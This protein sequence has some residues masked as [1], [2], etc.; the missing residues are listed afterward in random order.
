VDGET[1]AVEALKDNR[2]TVARAKTERFAAV[3]VGAAA[4]SRATIPTTL[5]TIEPLASGPV[6]PIFGG[7]GQRRAAGVPVLGAHD[8]RAAQG[9]RAHRMGGGR[10]RG[11]W[12]YHC[13]ILEPTSRE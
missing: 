2:M 13:H 12:M 4:P 8:Q 9:A 7:R 5:R 11:D 1:V 6:S 3:K 10:S